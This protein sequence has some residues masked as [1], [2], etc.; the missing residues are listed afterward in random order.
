VLHRG[1]ACPFPLFEVSNRNPHTVMNT[2]PSRPYTVI[3]R[4]TPLVPY[5][6][7]SPL[8][9][10]DASNP[11]AFNTYDTDPEQSNPRDGRPCPPP[12]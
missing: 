4:P 11:L 8:V 10:G 9:S 3:Y 1:P 12:Y 6:R 7:N 5:F 2:C